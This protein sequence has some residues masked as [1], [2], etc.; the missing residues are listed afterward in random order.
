VTALT[1]QDGKLVLRDGAL[2]VGQ[3]CCCGGCE[4]LPLCDTPLFYLNGLYY[5]PLGSGYSETC[6]LANTFPACVAEEFVCLNGYAATSIQSVSVSDCVVTI[7]WS[8]KPCSTLNQFNDPP[9][10]SGEP[11][12][13]DPEQIWSTQWQPC[14][15][16]AENGRIVLRFVSKALVAW[17]KPPA[18]NLSSEDPYVDFESASVE[19]ACGCCTVD[20]I[21][22]LT[23]ATQA[24]CESAGGVWAAGDACVV[25]ACSGCTEFKYLCHE[26]VFT[27]YTFEDGNSEPGP[28]EATADT[29]AVDAGLIY[30][31]PSG[32]PSQYNYNYNCETGVEDEPPYS[33]L[34]WHFRWRSVASCDECNSP[35]PD[36]GQNCPSGVWS[37]SCVPW[38]DTSL[39]AEQWQTFCDCTTVD[40]CADNPF[41]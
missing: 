31:P 40:I 9:D 25:D 38:N 22:D 26:K 10:C 37:M 13:Y 19:I 21:P 8:V 39:S 33:A 41:P 14:G 12:P 1:V 34:S 24:S 27:T 23:K 5:G 16:N 32:A 29:I 30:C 2:G 15:V 3:G 18:C 4:C 6:W 20:D 17:A 7:Q 11:Y 35:S 28:P 36:T